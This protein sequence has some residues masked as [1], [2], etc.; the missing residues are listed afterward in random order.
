MWVASRSGS[1]FE[2]TSSMTKPCWRSSLSAPLAMA[3]KNGL[4]MSRM[5]NP[6]VFVVP[7]RRLWA[8]KLG[9]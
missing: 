3:A 2:L 6:T 5:T 4:E 9:S 8:R 7:R 1:P